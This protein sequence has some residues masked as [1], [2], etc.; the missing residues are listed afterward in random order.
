MNLKY[1]TRYSNSP[2]NPVDYIINCL[3]TDI[4]S[5][6]QLNKKSLTWMDVNEKVIEEEIYKII[7][8]Y[9]DNEFMVDV[10]KKTYS[11]YIDLSV[12]LNKCN[13]D[14]LKWFMDN[15]FRAFDFDGPKIDEI[16]IPLNELKDYAKHYKGIK[17]DKEDQW[18]K[19]VFSKLNLY[20]WYKV[21]ESEGTVSCFLPNLTMRAFRLDYYGPDA[22]LF[23]YYYIS[24]HERFKIDREQFKKDLIESLNRYVYDDY[25]IPKLK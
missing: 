9:T 23:S 16:I 7:K 24:Q 11:F 19:L 25:F 22:L 21:Y 18:L 2:S 12:Y 15:N 14:V 6:N 17:L 4:Q 20:Q 1:P 3:K 10:F 5:F 8:V 13:Q